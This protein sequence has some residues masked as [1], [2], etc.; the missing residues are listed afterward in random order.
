MIEIPALW[1]IGQENAIFCQC[2]WKPVHH[3]L[4]NELLTTVL[5]HLV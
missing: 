4:R 5:L 1:L 2:T 3:G